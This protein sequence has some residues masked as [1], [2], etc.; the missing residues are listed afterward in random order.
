ML[1]I[2]EFNFHLSVRAH[3][4]LYFMQNTLPLPAVRNLGTEMVPLDLNVLHH[5]RDEFVPLVVLPALN[6]QNEGEELIE[7]VDEAM[8]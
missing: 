3:I 5:F 7:E 2:P 4:P 8:A 1:V 6:E